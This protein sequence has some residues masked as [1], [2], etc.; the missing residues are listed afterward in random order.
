VDGGATIAD[1]KTPLADRQPTGA[2]A[3]IALYTLIALLIAALCVMTYLYIRRR[4][5]EDR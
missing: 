2:E 3:P 1:G 4:A 5:K